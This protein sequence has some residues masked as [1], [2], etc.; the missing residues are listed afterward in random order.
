MSSRGACDEKPQAVYRR[1]IE[2]G[3]QPKEKPSRAAKTM[4]LSGN[5]DRMAWQGG[6]D[7]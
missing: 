6:V 1:K 7:G 5:P 4:G 3:S 2:T